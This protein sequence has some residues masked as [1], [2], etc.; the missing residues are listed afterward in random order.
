MRHKNN[1]L[2]N[3]KQLDLCILSSLDYICRGL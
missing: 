3:Q 1:Q 2:F